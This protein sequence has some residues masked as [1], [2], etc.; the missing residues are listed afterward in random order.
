MNLKE[1]IQNKLKEFILLCKSNNVKN[2]YAF[3]SA[4]NDEF[5]DST[6]DFDFLIEIEENDPIK[7]GERLL[8]I[9]DKLEYLFQRKVDLL[10]NSTI[11]NPVLRENIEKT[12]ILIYDGKSQKVFI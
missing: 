1:S 9:W 5:N 8:N 10:T 12:K 6:S 4:V 3:G 7:K 11:K 2:M